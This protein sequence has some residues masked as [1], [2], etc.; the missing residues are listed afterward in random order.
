MTPSLKCVQ[1]IN[2]ILLIKCTCTLHAAIHFNK[3][4]SEHNTS[5]TLHHPFLSTSSIKPFVVLSFASINKLVLLSLPIS[6]L[7]RFLSIYTR[8]LSIISTDIRINELDVCTTNVLSFFPIHSACSQ[9]WFHNSRQC[10]TSGWIY[11]Q[12]VNKHDMRECVKGME[13]C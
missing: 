11:V 1:A 12:F 13:R 4:V 7:L 2:S 9:S 3:D 6:Q 10:L 5:T 8:Q